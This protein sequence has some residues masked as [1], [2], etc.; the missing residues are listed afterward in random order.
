VLA[1]HRS[2]V[3]GIRMHD[4]EVARSAME[5]HLAGVAEAWQ[6]QQASEKDH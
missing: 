6:A 1:E 3:A 2:I 5:T 4:P